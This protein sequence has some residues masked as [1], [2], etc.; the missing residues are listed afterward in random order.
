M[1]KGP[2]TPLGAGLD[3]NREKS[4]RSLARACKL[5]TSNAVHSR[6]DLTGSIRPM[7]TFY[8]AGPPGARPKAGEPEGDAMEDDAR[9]T[10]A[11]WD[12]EEE[13]GLTPSTVVALAATIKSGNAIDLR[14]GDGFV[15]TVNGRD[16]HPY[17]ILSE[18]LS[19]LSE[20][21][22]VRPASH[23]QKFG[24]PELAR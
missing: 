7:A 13:E 10:G 16:W 8:S 4:L 19:D 2:P 21:N 20:L 18:L 3:G 22:H 15:A 24:L 11:Y 9:R 17:G 23:E 1:T 14:Y 5:W 12:P 6:S